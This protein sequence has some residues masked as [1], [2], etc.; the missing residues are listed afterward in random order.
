MENPRR[1]RV[2]HK[3]KELAHEVHRVTRGFPWPN[4]VAAAQLDDAV[5][6]ISSNI[7]EGCGRHNRLLGN[8]ELV[9]YC[10]MARGSAGEVRDRS[11]SVYDRQLIS[12]KDLDRLD[13]LG[14]AVEKMLSRLI[15]EL[16]RRDRGRGGA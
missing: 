16:Q 3:A 9:R 4:K 13:A 6:S 10:L 2:Y 8:A 11:E 15:V 1:L 14:E 7:A 5:D 12:K